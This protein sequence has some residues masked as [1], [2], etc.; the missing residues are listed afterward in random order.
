MFRH[1]IDGSEKAVWRLACKGEIPQN[2]ENR[3][4]PI[5]TENEITDNQLSTNYL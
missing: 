2:Y 1:F 5:F 4:K 3:N